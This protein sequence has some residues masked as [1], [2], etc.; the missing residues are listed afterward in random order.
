MKNISFEILLVTVYI[1]DRFTPVNVT[2][3]YR[4]FLQSIET[5]NGMPKKKKVEYILI[6]LFFSTY[7]FQM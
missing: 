4:T 5:Y 3:V 1:P 2:N 6:I 7:E